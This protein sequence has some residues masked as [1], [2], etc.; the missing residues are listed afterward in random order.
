MLHVDNPLAYEI[1]RSRSDPVLLN[2]LRPFGDPMTQPRLG[3]AQPPVSSRQVFRRSR[4][5]LSTMWGLLGR[6]APRPSTAPALTAPTSSAPALT[7][8]APCCR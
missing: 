7:T 4:T 3:Q 5:A 1:I 6:I 8:P 2:R